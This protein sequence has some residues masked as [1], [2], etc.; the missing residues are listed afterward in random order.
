MK[1]RLIVSKIID[2]EITDKDNYLVV[3]ETFT[4][5]TDIPFQ[6]AVMKY[7]GVHDLHGLKNI[8]STSEMELMEIAEREIEKQLE[9]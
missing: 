6:V 1:I 3:M 5:A 2:L 4:T 7:D 8:S 9:K